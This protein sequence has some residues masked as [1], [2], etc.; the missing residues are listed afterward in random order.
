MAEYC[1]KCAKEVLGFTD[2]ELRRG[3]FSREHE[4]CEGCGKMK[5]VLIRIR[6]SILELFLGNMR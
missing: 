3:V 1:K 5:R 2:A 6:P 4:L